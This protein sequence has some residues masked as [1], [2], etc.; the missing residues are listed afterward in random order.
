MPIALKMAASNGI[1]M[2]APQNVGL[3]TRAKGSTAIISIADSCSVAFMMPIL[4]V[5]AEPA[6]LANNSADTTGPSSRT[7]AKATSVP[8]ASAEP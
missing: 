4:A 8:S 5:M 2:N 6:R 3:S 1:E 7:S